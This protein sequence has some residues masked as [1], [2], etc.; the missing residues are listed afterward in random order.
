MRVRN[1]KPEDELERLL[2][3]KFYNPYDVLQ[4]DSS[5]TD[6]EIRKQFLA[7]SVLIHPDKFKDPRAK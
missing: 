2:G 4:V 6:E 1:L 5:A 7:I 3:E